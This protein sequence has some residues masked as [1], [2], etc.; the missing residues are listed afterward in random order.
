MIRAIRTFRA[1]GVVGAISF[2]LLACK[3]TLSQ[4]KTSHS[5]HSDGS[6]SSDRS[7]H[8]D[9][10]RLLRPT[11]IPPMT[12][13]ALITPITQIPSD[14]LR[15]PPIAQIPPITPMAPITKSQQGQIE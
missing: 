7:D 8:S 15:H 2:S 3:Y 4:S 14:P 6:D 1:I 9:T 10:L 11:Q 12:L 13:T 5:D